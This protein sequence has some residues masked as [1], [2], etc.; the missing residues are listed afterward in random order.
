MHLVFIDIIAEYWRKL[1]N[2]IH[3]FFFKFREARLITSMSFGLE[4]YA[5]IIGQMRNAK[6]ELL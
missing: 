3:I 1:H 5:A 4:G 6:K 2:E